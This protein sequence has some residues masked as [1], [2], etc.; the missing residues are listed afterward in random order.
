MVAN[1]WMICLYLFLVVLLTL[2]GCAG[3]ITQSP[4]G[5]TRVLAFTD[6]DLNEHGEKE[7]AKIRAQSLIE[8]D[9]AVTRYV[10][11]IARALIAEVRDPT[12]VKNWVVVVFKNDTPN[13]F[14]LPG[15]K[16]GVNTGMLLLART[17]H[18]LAAVLAHGI[19]SITARHPNERASK[20]L[21]ADV[22]AALLG[23]GRPSALGDPMAADTALVLEADTLGQL[24][25]A[26]AGFDPNASLLLWE[27]MQRDSGASP[28][29]LTEQRI[30]NLKG[31]LPRSLN[32]YEEARRIGKVPTCSP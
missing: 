25:M 16:V 9:V 6:Q 21:R 32:F 4:L 19:A 20:R 11:C 14:S 31:T 26:Q 12:G 3:G 29:P 10:A 2:T 28:S 27:S 7:F 22:G 8:T 1:L 30:E 23:L 18:Q 15:G 13:V 24:L 5:R 17:P